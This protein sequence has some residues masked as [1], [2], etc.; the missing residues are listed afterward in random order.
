MPRFAASPAWLRPFAALAAVVLGLILAWRGQTPPQPAPAGAPPL[1]FSALRAQRDIDVIGAQ[2]HPIGSP[3][4]GRVLAYLTARMAGL[5]L[6]P[7]VRAGPALDLRPDESHGRLS[8]ASVANLLGVLPGRDRTAPA[9]LLMAHYDSVPNSPGASDDAAGVASLLETV[10]ALKAQGPPARDVMVLFTDGEEAGLMGASAFFRGDPLARGVGFVVNLEARG[11]RGRALMFQTGAGDGPSVRLFAAAAR[12]PMASSL[13]GL[14][15]RYLPNDTD[16]TI[17][18]GHGLPGFNFAFLGGQFD[19]HSP[20]STPARMDAGTLQDLGTQ[21]LAVTRALAYAPALPRRG[22]DVVY[23]QMFGDGLA[24]YPLWGGWVA[25]AVAAGLLVLAWRRAGPDALRLT[26]AA[27]GAGGGVI[28]LAAAAGLLHDARLAVGVGFGFVAQRPL[29]AQAGRWEL[30][31]ALLALGV[32]AFMGA[33]A[34]RGCWRV[35]AGAGLT[36]ALGGCALGLAVDGEALIAGG[37]ILVLSWPCLRRPLPAAEGWLGLLA[38]GLVLAMAAQAAVPEAAFFLAWP[39]L[40]GALAAALSGLGRRGG[41]GAVLVIAAIGAVTVGWVGGLAHLLYL[42]VDLPEALALPLFAAALTLWPLLTEGEAA[43]APAIA[44]G[45]LVLA[46]LIVTAALRL[47]DPWSARFPQISEVYYL[48]DQD[49]GRAWRVD[50][51]LAPTAW[52]RAVLG[53]DGGAAGQVSLWPFGGRIPAAPARWLAEA[54]PQVAI[55][56]GADGALW[57]KAQPTPGAR[58]LSLR[59]KPS[60]PMILIQA[61]GAPAGLALKPGA[62]TRVSWAAPAGGLSLRLVG[63]AGGALQLRYVELFDGWPA[64]ARPLPPRPA[65]LA[66]FDTSDSL[67]VCGS[68]ALGW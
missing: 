51:S 13:T 64:Q 41:P 57:L 53:A 48:L 18:L 47:Q 27:R 63:P 16:L 37:L 6:A 54:P 14:V 68:R 46:G 22:R 49:A 12:R 55:S 23:S 33:A 65:D 39:L 20:S 40:A 43:V 58:V 17:A 36:L 50:A 11:S 30:A 67:V 3:A 66:P 10:R 45:A 38:L 42:G 52:S 25:L 15:F 21:T 62:W 32:L 35:T 31:L 44:G 61:D 1:V 4:D 2:A 34:A 28:L 19:Y 8:G 59:L 5:G 56:R 60:A 24:A 9:L 26:D 29:E 7:Q